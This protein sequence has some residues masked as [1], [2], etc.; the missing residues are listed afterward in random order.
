VIDD[1][2]DVT[3]SALFWERRQPMTDENTPGD[4]MDTTDDGTAE[5]DDELLRRM[6][7]ALRGD[8]P[9]PDTLIAQAKG[10]FTWLTIDDD[11]ASL[12]E[13]A[14]DSA[15]DDDLAGV[16]GGGGPRLLSFERD[17]VVIEVEVASD[18]NR[19]RVVGQVS[20]VPATE[21]VLESASGARTAVACDELGQF[22]TDAVPPGP[23]RVVVM[24]AGD[25]PR[26]VRGDWVTV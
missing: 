4:E 16:R 20:G 19:R 25:P 10:A 13:L 1:V 15:V 11:L 21:V 12:A 3:S 22:S 17:E 18:R 2:S 5:R 24:L 6:A 26:T 23:L 14:Y 7:E 8:D 9:V